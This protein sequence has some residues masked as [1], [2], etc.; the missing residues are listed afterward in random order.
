M[1]KNIIYYA[2][3]GSAFGSG[4]IKNRVKH[5]ILTHKKRLY[6]HIYYFHAMCNF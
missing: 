1:I 2:Y 3:D 6:C 5:H 4:G